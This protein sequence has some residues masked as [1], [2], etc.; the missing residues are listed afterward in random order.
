MLKSALAIII[1]CV[2]LGLQAQDTLKTTVMT[3]PIG[4][5]A[6]FETFI[7]KDKFGVDHKLKYKGVSNDILRSSL[8][9]KVNLVAKDFMAV[10]SEEL[11]TDI[12]YQKKIMYGLDRFKDFKKDLSK[13][14]RARICHYIIELMD[15]IDLKS[16]RGLL[17]MFTYG[18]DPSTIKFEKEKK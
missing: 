8:S 6:A 5:K 2:S 16:S 14:D 9:K 11:P 17:N 3:T 4:A 18:F 15:I 1:L 12:K 7:K 13:D 10:S